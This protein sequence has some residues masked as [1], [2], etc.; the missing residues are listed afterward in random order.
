MTEHVCQNTFGA[1]QRI[2]QVIKRGF[3]NVEAHAGET[4]SSNHACCL[5]HSTEHLHKFIARFHERFQHCLEGRRAKGNDEI[6][7]VYIF[8]NAGQFRQHGHWGQRGHDARQIFLQPKVGRISGKIAV[9]IRPHVF[10]FYRLN[11]EFVRQLLPTPDVGLVVQHVHHFAR[12]RQGRYGRIRLKLIV[13]IQQRSAQLLMV[14][15]N[16]LAN[17][18]FTAHHIF[19]SAHKTVRDGAIMRLHIINFTNP[20]YALFI[21]CFSF[22]AH[23]FH[24]LILPMVQAQLAPFEGG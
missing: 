4:R 7:D 21:I 10:T 8:R 22:R 18:A 14:V 17:H 5:A 15:N 12:V 6:N 20:V 3:D 16:V 19:I 23:K 2:A 11:G 9:L 1:A 24:W 13:E